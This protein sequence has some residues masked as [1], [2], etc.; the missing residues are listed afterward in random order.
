[1]RN[2]LDDDNFREF[3][4]KQYS[5]EAF[6]N[7]TDQNKEELIRSEEEIWF[8]SLNNE[9]KLSDLKRLNL[10]IDMLW[11]EFQGGLIA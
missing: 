2:L 9:D 3:V 5:L 10:D 4:T 8:H 7:L 11:D 1:M 6:N